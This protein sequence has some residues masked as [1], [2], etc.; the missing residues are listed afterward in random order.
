MDPRYRAGLLL[1][2]F[3][4]PR[5]AEVC[6]LRVDDVGF[7]RG[8]AHPVQQHPA[9]PLKPEISRTPVPIPQNLALALSRHVEDYSTTWVLR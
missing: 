7:M 3:A 6:G 1:A 9:D 5:L 8:V 2:A 4:G